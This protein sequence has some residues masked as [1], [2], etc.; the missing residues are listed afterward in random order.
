METDAD[1]L[2]VREDMADEKRWESEKL[3]PFSEVDFSDYSKMKSITCVNHPTARYLSKDPY[4]RGLHFIHSADE[5]PAGTEC[6]CPF[7]DLRVIRE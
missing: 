7:S 6:P 4:S 5:M 2:R 3:I 1:I